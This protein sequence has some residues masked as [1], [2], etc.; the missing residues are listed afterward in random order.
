MNPYR[1]LPLLVALT[2][3]ILSPFT[4]PAQHA[5][6]P[7]ARAAFDRLKTLAGEW[8]GNIGERGTGQETTVG[9][10]LIAAGSALAET[11]FAGPPHEM[12][13]V[14]HLDGEKL[15]LTHY[16]A[17]GNQ[18]KLALTK[19][20]TADTLDF[21]FVSGTNMKSRKDDHMH[22][23]RLRFEGPNA[24]TTEWDGYK[25]GRKTGTTKFFLTRKG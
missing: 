4:A 3:L 14:Y 20:S 1:R 8:R 16:C 10:R 5:A 18:P 17:A 6:S 15:V 11:L 23:L 2:G 19:K 9:Y 7:S 25:D 22:S 12:I 13:T 24:I 21:D